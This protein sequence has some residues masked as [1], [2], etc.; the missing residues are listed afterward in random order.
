MADWLGATSLALRCIG[1]V[2]RLNVPDNS[3]ALI[4]NADRYETRANETVLDFA[5]HYATFFLPARPYHPQDK[6]KVKV[7]VKIESAVQVVE[8][9]I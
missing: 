2:L 7:K 6:D 8:H 4:A 3:R 5:R 9:W 1:G